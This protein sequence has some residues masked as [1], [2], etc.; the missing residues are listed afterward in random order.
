MG[1]DTINFKIK[2]TAVSRSS[3]KDVILL[4]PINENDIENYHYD[5]RILSKDFDVQE[6]SDDMH[7]VY[8][9]DIIGFFADNQET[10][11]YDIPA[12]LLVLSAAT[13]LS[14]N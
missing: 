6:I 5:I 11:I 3:N 2:R 12:R 14:F 4:E 10:K 8:S 7:F 13:E 9:E 1:N